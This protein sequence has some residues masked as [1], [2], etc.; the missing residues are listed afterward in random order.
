MM[1]QSDTLLKRP[2]LRYHGAK[3]RLAPWILRHFPPHDCYVESFGGAAGV[4][5]QKPRA[6]AE[7][8]NDLDGDVVNFFRVL[9]DQSMRT[10]LIEAVALTPYSR[11]EFDL[12][13]TFTDDVIERA[14][15]TAIRAQMGFGSAGAV[16]G[17][18]GFR[19]DT[20][21]KYGTA[22]QLWAEYP[23]AIA[24]AGERLATVLIENRPGLTVI[25]DHDA[26]STLHFVDPP[27]VHATRELRKQ[28]GY[29]HEMSD[30][31]HVE[32]LE[33]LHRLEGMVVLCGYASPLYRE[34]LVGWSHHTKSVSASGG[35][36]GVVRQES[37]WLNPACLAALNSATGS[38]FGG[39]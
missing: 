31:D 38:L 2:A 20:R 36:G 29:R 27:Y 33:A 15:R 11:D 32:L 18:T 35:R 7:V 10:T 22:Q 24:A 5:L 37:V 28:G 26:P 39:G 8:Y 17:S 23:S 4:L 9:R 34:R 13:W 25:A 12:A 6:Y 14:R 3:F 16:K 30:H 21:R 19:T 1:S